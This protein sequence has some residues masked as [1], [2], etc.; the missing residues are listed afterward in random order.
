MTVKFENKELIVFMGDGTRMEMGSGI[1]LDVTRYPVN[2][3]DDVNHYRL[4]KTDNR[5]VIAGIKGKRKKN[6]DSF[7]Y[8]TVMGVQDPVSTKIMPM[9]KYMMFL[10]DHPKEMKAMIESYARFAADI[11]QD[12]I[13]AGADAVLIFDDYG[14]NNSTFLSLPMWEEFTYPYLKIITEAI[15]EAGGA[16]ILHSCGYQMTL[17][18]Y[19]VEAGLDALQAFQEGAGNS[20]DEGYKLYG[21]E[22][23]FI[24]GIDIQQGESW[25]PEELKKDILR[26][27]KIG[28]RNGHHILGTTHHLQ[29]TMSNE[30]ISTIFDTVKE[31][32][33]GRYD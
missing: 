11:A 5:K 33:Q 7:I 18:P 26:N 12:I 19:Y 3:L 23:T 6:P 13:K 22:L 9:D 27:Y 10:I 29:Y 31:I 32:Q 2:S 15:H 30:N 4:K 17:L 16:A 28:G 21:D 14:F 8:G 24:T 1:Y 25:S 20:F